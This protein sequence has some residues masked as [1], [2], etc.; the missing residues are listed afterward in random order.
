VEQGEAG[1]SLA[2]DRPES[3]R[4]YNYYLGG[5]TNHAVDREAADQVMGLFPTVGV[6][7]RVN[8]AF[9][10]RAVRFLAGREGIR[11][12]VDLGAGIPVAPNLHEV[13]QAAAPDSRVVYV[14]NDPI[15]EAHAAALLDSSERGAT[16]YVEA[17]VTDPERLLA[18]V[19]ASGGVDFD[20]PVS[21]SLHAL[22]HFVPGD[23]AYQIVET[24]VDRLAP[25][26][27]LCLTHCTQD[28]DP[29]TWQ[30]IVDVYAKAGTPAQ[31]RTRAEVLSFFDGLELVDPGLVVA[32]RWRPE[33]GSGPTSVT[34]EMVSLYAG[35][36]RK[37]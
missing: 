17:D 1:K 34:D 29:A 13:A 32:H 21:L 6:F 28:F 16:T 25:G 36:A 9:M 22:L 27:Y 4:M 33:E 8:R 15:V 19:E 26:S 11:Q 5:T 14:D 3:A 31:V 20:R 37:P 23:R 7:A 2:A 10:H 35:V 30:A 18:A 12:F 24:L